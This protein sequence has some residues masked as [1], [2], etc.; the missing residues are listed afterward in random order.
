MLNFDAI[1]ELLKKQSSSLGFDGL[2]RGIEKEN[3]RV[4][5]KGELATSSHP[6][7][8][9]SSLCHQEITTDFSESLVE[10]ITPPRAKPSQSL[11]DLK[12][13][14]A[15]VNHA[16]KD[17]LLWPYSMPPEIQ[18]VEDIILAQYGV[19][20]AAKLKTLYRKGLAYRYGKIMQ[21]IAGIHYNISLPIPF[22][23]ALKQ[24]E[25]S[26]E[27]DQ[28]YIS[29]CYMHLVR[30]FYAYYWIL[31]YLFGTS[32]ACMKTSLMHD[33]DFKLD[34]LDKQ[35]VYAPFATSL[36]LSQ[37]GYHNKH[38][39]Q[40]NISYESI[41]QYARSLLKATQ[42]SIPDYARIGVKGKEGYRQISDAVLQ[43]EN[44]YYIPIRPKRVIKCGERSSSAL[45]TS[46]VE[47]I[48]IRAIDLNPLKPTG[49]GLKDM[50]FLEVFAVFCAI[51][52]E[53]D[54]TRFKKYCNK[55]RENFIRVATR[56]R[57]PALSLVHRGKEV[58]F[59]DHAKAL[60]KKLGVVA[61][62]M[63]S[64]INTPRYEKALKHQETKIED[65]TETPSAMML[66]KY[67]ASGLT[68]TDF[69]MQLAQENNQALNKN[70]LTPA[71]MEE[72]TAKA[73]RSIQ[74]QRMQ[75][76][77]D[78]LSFDAYLANYFKDT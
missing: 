78:T 68:M 35:S 1:I 56:G 2:R 51:Q 8:L 70:E 60:F 23:L 55:S 74:K 20:N 75:E 29:S 36:R 65:V 7:A 30:Q 32:P 45:L 52:P 58:P 41:D 66:S 43:I 13:I 17:E 3:L 62:L 39:D 50:A 16:I 57:D 47:Y 46:G 49:I 12:S 59:Y 4:N 34:A 24:I 14:T 33:V 6:S 64:S 10:V 9:G 53:F 40:L 25:K 69:I 54:Q 77:K 38:E 31:P 26:Q 63:D 19:S 5:K 11:A 27:D 48:E 61:R 28:T 72:F 73:I 22:L 44:E 42:K 21:I 37:L 67:N 15:F 71:Q 18:T 76:E